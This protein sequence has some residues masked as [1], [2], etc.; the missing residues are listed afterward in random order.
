M[1]TVT[2]SEP[3]L[4]TR[5]MPPERGI[6]EEDD[7]EDR[8]QKHDRQQAVGDDPLQA[9]AEVLERHA[10][11]GQIAG[12]VAVQH[13]RRKAHQAVPEGGFD[14]RRRA[15]L[16]P[17]HRRALQ[18]V[19]HRAEQAEPRQ[20]RS[21][22]IDRSGAP[23]RHDVVRDEAERERRQQLD[24]AAGK[25]G[26]HQPR[27]VRARALQGEP[28]QVAR[29]HAPRRQ[30]AIEHPGFVLQRG[31]ALRRDPHA[32]PADRVD[33]PVAP[34]RSRQQRD[35]LA[36]LGAERQQGVAVAPPPLA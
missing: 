15:P 19:K 23:A 35:G 30:G 18:Q 10:R 31:G 9:V 14:P 22:G 29:L 4:K 34:E 5:A 8:K 28:Q 21:R 33:L 17:H 2:S 13:G 36:V 16:E 25:P 32:A 20:R 6:V 7:A 1:A 26:E 12:R 27:Q 11:H 3:R 24:E